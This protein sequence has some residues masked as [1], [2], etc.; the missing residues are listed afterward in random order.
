MA[1]PEQGQALAGRL[2]SLRAFEVLIFA[3]MFILM[4][5]CLAVAPFVADPRDEGPSAGPAFAA[6]TGGGWRS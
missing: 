1:P 5:L 3:A 2:R 6:E 4:A